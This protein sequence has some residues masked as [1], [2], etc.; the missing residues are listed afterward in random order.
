MKQSPIATHP[1]L[2]NNYAPELLVLDKGEGVYL[3]DIAGKSYLDF[4]SGIAVNALGYGREDLAETGY[5]QM[6]KLIHSSNLYTT[7]PTLSLAKRM[8]KM[9]KFA[10]VQF[11]NSGSEAN[12]AAIKYARLY[13][14][15]TRGAGHF[16]ILSLENGFHG[17]TMGA[18]SCTPSPKYQEPFTP[19]VPGMTSIPFNDVKR[20]E[21]VLDGSFACVIVEVI[22]GEG[23]LRAC[24]SA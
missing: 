8:T 15:R 12:E 3:T 21:T 16:K 5:R 1:P 6:Q 20:L 9:G 4:G 17:R 22:Q 23:G 10:A 19:L 7:E 14:L 11:G 13:A 24:L 18:L 2:P